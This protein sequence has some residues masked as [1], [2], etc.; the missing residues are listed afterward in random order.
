MNSLACSAY[1][2]SLR[3]PTPDGAKPDLFLFPAAPSFSGRSV[4]GRRLYTDASNENDRSRARF[5]LS[6]VITQTFHSKAGYAWSS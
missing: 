5:P 6:R 2:N 3:H 1:W 4:S